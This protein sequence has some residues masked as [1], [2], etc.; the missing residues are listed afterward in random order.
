MIDLVS[1]NVRRL[2]QA[3]EWSEHELARR[4]GV[5]QKAINNLLNKTTGCTIT[6]AEK[7][8]KPFGLTG[9]QLMIEKIPADAA[10][11]NTLT[12]LVLKFTSADDQGRA[13][14]RSAVDRA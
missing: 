5:S 11:S 9:W 7:L 12:N 8:A 13:F 3:M 14:I 4:S 1:A 10:F 6:T 2:M